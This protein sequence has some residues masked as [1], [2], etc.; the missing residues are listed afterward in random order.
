MSILWQTACYT[1]APWWLNVKTHENWGKLGQI[2]EVLGCFTYC[3]NIWPKK[4]ICDFKPVIFTLHILFSFKEGDV[5]FC[6]NHFFLTLPLH[7]NKTQDMFYI[8][9]HFWGKMLTQVTKKWN[10]M[11]IIMKWQINV[12]LHLHLAI[13]HPNSLKHHTI[14]QCCHLK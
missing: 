7:P 6:W 1:E 4:L 10:K 5:I 3:K 9:C 13:D 11:I 12:N 14:V 8:L 2:F